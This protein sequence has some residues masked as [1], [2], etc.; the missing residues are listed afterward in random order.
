M[1]SRSRGTTVL[2]VWEKCRSPECQTALEKHSQLR[3]KLEDEKYAE[4]ER[5]TLL[6][7]SYQK[8][9][10][11]V[12]EVSQEARRINLKELSDAM[13]RNTIVAIGTM[14]DPKA[15][16]I[17]LR[18]RVMK[19][20]D[21]YDAEVAKPIESTDRGLLK[22][23]LVKLR[24]EINYLPD[25][26]RSTSLFMNRA[27]WLSLVSFAESMHLDTFAMQDHPLVNTIRDLKKVLLLTDENV[28]KLYSA[29]AGLPSSFSIGAVCLMMDV[30][31]DR[32]EGSDSSSEAGLKR[33]KRLIAAGGVHSFAK[34]MAIEE[35]S[36]ALHIV[37]TE[38]MLPAASR[39]SLDR[40]DRRVWSPCLREWFYRPQ[41]GS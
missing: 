6:Y 28:P 12:F 5:E 30:L 22:N 20:V 26:L 38:D 3:H 1:N 10:R 15:A 23:D 34:D 14:N 11:S 17:G 24:S 40:S 36:K 25:S 9:I 27:H 16:Y 41:S 39:T 33:R 13:Y 37:H 21:A 4:E 7:D 19:A 2:S 35:R 31:D 29:V 18:N 32:L 8:E